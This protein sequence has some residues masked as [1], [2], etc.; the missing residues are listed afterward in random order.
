MFPAH[1]RPKAHPGPPKAVPGQEQGPAAAPGPGPGGTAESPPQPRPG[2]GL[3]PGTARAEAPALA[4]PRQP[5]LRCRPGDYR[6][7]PARPR[8]KPQPR[9]P[10]PPRR[11]V[12]R[13]HAHLELPQQPQ[14]GQQPSPAARRH[15]PPAAQPRPQLLLLL[16]L[17]LPV[18]G[19]APGG[20]CVGKGVSGGGNRVPKALAPRDSL[21]TKQNDTDCDCNEKSSRRRAA[22]GHERCGEGEV[23]G[24]SSPLFRW[25]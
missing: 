10:R 13:P 2:R 14:E 3:C 9:P 7:N 24:V 6:G 12:P 18:P 11:A 23:A 15:R 16:L 20:R 25:V 22:H 21:T 4:D 5:R 19:R 8:L 1:T 17:L